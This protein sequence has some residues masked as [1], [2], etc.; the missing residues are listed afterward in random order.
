LAMLI[1]CAMF[2]VEEKSEMKLEAGEWT[3]I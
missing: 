1:T 2:F 3:Y